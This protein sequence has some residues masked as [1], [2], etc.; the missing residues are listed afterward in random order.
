MSTRCQIGFY[1]AGETDLNA[2]QVLVWLAV[3][4]TTI[5]GEA[6]QMGRSPINPNRWPPLNTLPMQEEPHGHHL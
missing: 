3:C 4:A 6:T 2:W 5:W 1:E